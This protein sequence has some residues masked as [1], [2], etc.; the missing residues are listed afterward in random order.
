MHSTPTISIYAFVVVLAGLCLPG[1][2]VWALFRL[3]F[4]RIS[5]GGSREQDID[6][7]Q[8]E[9]WL[10]PPSVRL[11]PPMMPPAAP[12]DE[13]EYF[14]AARYALEHNLTPPPLPPRTDREVW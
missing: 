5:G 13:R 14:Q 2:A 7:C 3:L 9:E 6:C 1:V 8:D 12:R 10:S 11:Q 4:G